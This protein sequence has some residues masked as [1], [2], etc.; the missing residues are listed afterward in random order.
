[1]AIGSIFDVN[2]VNFVKKEIYEAVMRFIG[3]M[4]IWLPLETDGALS[5]AIS[6]E[7]CKTW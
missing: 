5:P 7:G 2:E 4:A 6:F 1:M 3:L